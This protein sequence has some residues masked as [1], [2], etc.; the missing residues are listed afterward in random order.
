MCLVFPNIF[1]RLERKRTFR[2]AFLLI[3]VINT[4]WFAWRKQYGGVWPTNSNGS[5]R[6]P[7]RK[8]KS[9]ES[10][11]DAVHS[12]VTLHARAKSSL[13]CFW[14]HWFNRE[15]G[16]CQV[17]CIQEFEYSIS[18]QHTVCMWV[19]Q[20]VCGCKSICKFSLT[21]FQRLLGPD[22]IA[23][24]HPSLTLDAHDCG[25]DSFSTTTQLS[26]QRGTPACSLL[27]NGRGLMVDG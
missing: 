2:R 27:L 18:K 14:K 8:L 21:S 25:S 5:M 16:V 13:A 22:G 11:T 26:Q 15:M 19:G 23:P 7:H 17:S 24:A 9:C 12:Y 4:L 10:Y 3:R 20:R 1:S 6:K